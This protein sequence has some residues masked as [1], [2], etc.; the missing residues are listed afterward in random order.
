MLPMRRSPARHILAFGLGVL[1]AALSW[2][3][4][5][6][7]EFPPELW[8]DM[9][10]AAKLRPPMHEFPLLWQF[11]VSRVVDFCGVAKSLEAL[12]AAGAV[13]LG[14][15]TVLT[16]YFFS[17]VIISGETSC[18]IGMRMKKSRL[19][20]YALLSAGVM[21]FVC[22]E[23][24]WLAG[25]V[26]SPEMSVLLLSLL[27]LVFSERALTGNSY[28]SLLAL[29]V[30]SG[31]LAAETVLGFL[32]PVFCA[33][34]VR[35]KNL[36]LIAGENPDEPAN[37][38]VLEVGV[39]RMALCFIVSWATI[40]ALNL[41][42]YRS[43]SMGAETDVNLFTGVVKY[44]LNYFSSVLRS[45]SPLG[46]ILMTLFGVGPLVVI[47][48]RKKRLCDV[49]KLLPV[50]HALFLTVVGFLGALQSSG[51]KG[52]HFWRLTE[53]AISSR[54]LLCVWVLAASLC[55]I[56][57]MY[58]FTVDAY[59][60]NHMRVLKEA[61]PEV[62]IGQS[63]FLT[64]T[65]FS[66][67]A[68]SKI[69]R[70]AAS[71]FP[72]A[73]LA[74]VLPFKFDGTYREISSIVNEVARRSA[75]ESSGVS[76]LVTDGSFDAG[77]EL[78]AAEQ[79]RHL[80]AISMM[81][82]NSK[83]DI[84]LRLRGETNEVRRSIL[85]VGTAEALRTWMKESDPCVSNIALQVGMELW[86]HKIGSLPKA[87][88]FVMRTDGF[89][90]GAAEKG[91]KAARDLAGRILAVCGD[92][93]SFDF[94]KNEV[95]R[96]LVFAVWRLSRMCRMRSSEAERAQNFSLSEEES[97]LADRLDK[98]N[99]EWR[100]VQERMDW[101]AMQ[102]RVRLTPQEG[103]NLG[104]ER[105]DFKLA[106]IYA[107]QIIDV[108]PD[109]LKANF[110]IAMAMFIDGQYG[111]AEKH[112][113]KCAEISPREPAVLNNLAIA[114]LRLGRYAEAETNAV[115]AL[116]IMPDSH[117]IKTTLRHIRK[118]MNASRD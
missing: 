17:G 51:F 97:D 9:A 65:Q 99:P 58:I 75:E 87:G 13:S 7:F 55:V 57:C 68:L 21:L 86:K 113:R 72:F 71:V 73:A 2:F 6:N 10:V 63:V 60:R 56:H 66:Y 89:A 100:R 92:E 54:Y 74:L 39:R 95:N 114:L 53:G 45:F 107:R 108:N 112:L 16:F 1:T 31:V 19:T 82:G 15:L 32:P 28:R 37:R 50:G 104:L 70:L 18:R 91:A 3:S 80:K 105:A 88:G 77:V 34:A 24:V 115:K 83:Y 20:V 44:L 5:N 111:R 67:R 14:L 109:D 49:K 35:I 38:L 33:I 96:L 29:G 76:M 102:E 98:I 43:N 110:A 106:S 40:V 12:K 48:V 117:E 8:E 4:K 23:P 36:N 90:P 25:R 118:A 61:Y 85:E 11:V 41:S 64:S 94:E 30:F 42:F 52:W 79:G 103:L 59:C 26:F 62:M 81:S 101:K 84:A 69:L 93:D 46:F 27:V 22:S 78:A 116:E 47:A